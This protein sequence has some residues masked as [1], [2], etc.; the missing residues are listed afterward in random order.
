M[1][2]PADA[3]SQL[4]APAFLFEDKPPVIIL[5]DLDNVSLMHQ[6]LRCA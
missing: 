2:P 3:K 1:A 6:N 4:V 5:I